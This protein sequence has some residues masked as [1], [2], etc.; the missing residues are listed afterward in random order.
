MKLLKPL[1]LT[2]IVAQAVLC[3]WCYF[4]GVW[5]FMEHIAYS[6]QLASVLLELALGLIGIKLIRSKKTKGHLIGGWIL[7]SICSGF[8]IFVIFQ[9][10]ELILNPPHY[11]F[12]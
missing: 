4:K 2:I 8:A 6:I 5:G 11:P 9:N 3:N 7:I 10:I 1:F 12:G